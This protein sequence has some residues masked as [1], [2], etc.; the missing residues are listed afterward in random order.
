[1]NASTESLEARAAAAFLEGEEQHTYWMQHYQELKQQYPDRFVA[2]SD[3]VV[4]AEGEDLPELESNLRALGLETR[5]TWIHF[6][7][8]TP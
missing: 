1:M 6:V 8:A 7:E 3:A 2:V 5:D 4:V